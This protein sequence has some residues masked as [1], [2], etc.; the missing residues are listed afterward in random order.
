MRQ[1]VTSRGPNGSSYLDFAATPEIVTE[2]ARSSARSSRL[3]RRPLE[4]LGEF[5]SNCRARVFLSAVSLSANVTT[6][7]CRISKDPPFRA[8]RHVRDANDTLPARPMHRPSE[9]DHY[10]GVL[11]LSFRRLRDRVRSGSKHCCIRN[12]I[13]NGGS[14]VSHTPFALGVVVNLR[15][16]R[17]INRASSAT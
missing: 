7:R 10:V 3:I 15:S 12:L 6:R 5:R 13:E 8:T 17:I 4:F 1:R 9:F 16:I 2:V 11:P 14:D